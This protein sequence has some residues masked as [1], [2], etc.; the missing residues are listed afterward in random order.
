[1]RK[2]IVISFI[3]LDGVMQAPG[4]PEEDSKDSFL[5]GGW[6]V[7]Y[8]EGILEKE[9]GSQMEQTFELLLGRKTY[10]IFAANWP[11]IDPNSIINCVNKYVVTSKPIPDDTDVWKNSK[12]IDGDIVEKVKVLKNE[13]AP[14]LHVH[15]SGQLIQTLLKNDLVDEL[16]LKIYPITLGTGQ[17]LFAAGTIPTA[18]K[19][20]ECKLTSSGV[21]IA[22]Y[23]KSGDVKLGSF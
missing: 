17:R 1:M 11:E 14:D 21:I 12:R 5:Y 2:I 6:S 8:W 19:V 4:G 18:F 7:A 9:M 20:K 16:W 10:D 13:D 3:T 15:G 22:S 23:E